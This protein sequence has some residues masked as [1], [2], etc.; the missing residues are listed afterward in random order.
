MRIKIYSSEAMVP[1]WKRVDCPLWVEN[2]SLPHVGWGRME[3]E[4]VPASGVMWTLY[5]Y[6]VK[7]EL[8]CNH[9]LWVVNKR[10]TLRIQAAKMTFFQRK[11]GLTTFT[12]AVELILSCR[13]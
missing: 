3:R 2:E 6:V 10:L 9:E 13:R 8:G 5:E 1:R 4:I 7:R 11:R 12:Q